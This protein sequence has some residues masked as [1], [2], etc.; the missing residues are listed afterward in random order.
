MKSNA[1]LRYS[2][3]N[4]KS[5][6]LIFAFFQASAQEARRRLVAESIRGTS[7]RLAERRY[8]HRRQRE[9]LLQ[10]RRGTLRTQHKRKTPEVSEVGRTVAAPMG[11]AIS[12]TRRSRAHPQPSGRKM[13]FMSDSED[14]HP[15]DSHGSNTMTDTQK[16]RLPVR[17]L[18]G[19]DLQTSPRNIHSQSDILATQG[20]TQGKQTVEYSRRQVQPV[21]S[22]QDHVKS[23]GNSP[24]K[25]TLRN[26]PQ[27]H[28]GHD[29]GG[30][31]HRRRMHASV[32]VAAGVHEQLNSNPS[33]FRD[34]HSTHGK[35]QR[36]FNAEEPDG[37]RANMD[38][39]P[40]MSPL[41]PASPAPEVGAERACVLLP[42]GTVV[43]MEA[44]TVMCREEAAQVAEY[45]AKDVATLTATP[46][47]V[48]SE[49]FA[50]A[51]L[52][53]TK[54]VPHALDDPAV[55]SVI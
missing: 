49:V 16:G 15:T 54:I 17:P 27:E 34:T 13:H 11:K 43:W 47:V 42:N 12:S 26:S 45:A 23:P 31:K 7:Q 18:H 28:R 25:L 22:D 40:F 5:I 41:M 30:H 38:D 36:R 39:N 24:A 8:Q 20:H 51:A 32:P 4:L 44:S 6:F 37:H 35:S 50:Q 10:E 53:L 2:T 21:H 9:R 3:I 33:H 29:I 1:S 52:E 14:I 48:D 55:S 46:A 19:D